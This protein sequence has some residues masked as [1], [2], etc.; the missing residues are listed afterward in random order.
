MIDKIEEKIKEIYGSKAFFCEAQGYDYKNFSKK[1]RTV[2]N[3]IAFLNDFLKPLKLEVVI[4]AV[5]M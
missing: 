1:L 2:E 4:K 3:Q 5:E